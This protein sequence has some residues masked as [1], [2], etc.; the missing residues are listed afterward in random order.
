MRSCTWRCGAGGCCSGS[1]A[2][3]QQ[4]CHCARR[5][6]GMPVSLWGSSAAACGGAARMETGAAHGL[7]PAPCS[8]MQMNM[9][10]CGA[11]GCSS[12]AVAHVQQPAHCA[13]RQMDMPVSL[14]GSNAAAVLLELLPGA[15]LG[16]LCTMHAQLHPSMRFCRPPRSLSSCCSC[17]CVWCWDSMHECAVLLCGVLQV[18]RGGQL[19]RQS[20]SR[21]TPTSS[22]SQQPAPDDAYLSGT[23]ASRCCNCCI[24]ATVLP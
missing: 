5:Q 14:G 10:V 6:T 3:V 17:C 16:R 11:G 12:G 15:R 23:K 22:L 8:R 9:P 2:H 7:Q 24:C 20:F 18:V 13:H 4:P 19:F 1:V 21:G